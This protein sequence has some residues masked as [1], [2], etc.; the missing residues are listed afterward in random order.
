MRLS[1]TFHRAVSSVVI[2]AMLATPASAMAAVYGYVV[3]SGDDTVSVIDLDAG[4]AI[5][6]FSVGDVPLGVA[7]NGTGAYVVNT[8]DDTVSVVDVTNGEV[9]ATISVPADPR[10]VVISGTGVYVS[11][12]ATDVVSVIDTTSNA[13][14]LSISVPN[15]PF[16]MAVS[17][18]GVFVSQS[19]ASAVSI[20]DTTTGTV[21]STLTVGAAPNGMAASGTGMY[22]A[23]G[24]DNTVSVID[25]TTNTVEDLISV[26][27]LPEGVATSGTGVYVVNLNGPTVS[28]ID[29]STDTVDATITV[30]T[31]PIVAAAYDG[32]IYV[33]NAASDTVSVISVATNTV[34]DT[35]SVGD[36]PYGIAFGSDISTPSVS[37][38]SSATTVAETDGTFSVT[39]ALSAATFQD[40]SV[41]FTIS[42][43]A[44]G[45]G[46]DYTLN[47]PSPVIINNAETSTGIS[48]TVVADGDFEGTEQFTITL[49]TPTNASLGATTTH[50]VTITSADASSL[51]S[52]SEANAVNIGGGGVR[53]VTLEMKRKAAELRFGQMLGSSSSST[54][55]IGGD[56][57]PV[58]TDV[59]KG[60]WFYS[61]VMELHR[62]RI[63]SGYKD[64][65]GNDL[66]LYGPADSV[67]YGEF[68]KMLLLFTGR[69]PADVQN[70]VHW[71]DPYVLA[72]RQR[73]IRVYQNTQLNLD[74]FV[75]RGV[76]VR[77]L[78]EMYG[79]APDNAPRT[80]FADLP[81]D[82]PYA[83]D[84][85]K[86]V[87]LGL[88]SGDATGNTV[89]PDA[90]LN[91]AELA[92]LL[93]K[94][95]ETLLSAVRSS[96]SSSSV[97]SAS[98]SVSV[99]T[100]GKDI[101]HVWSS[102]LNVRADSRITADILWKA[103]Q[104]DAMEVLEI[105][106]EAW[107]HIR[108]LDGREG[109]VWVEY[110]EER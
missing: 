93:L 62:R 47:T 92:K 66:H 10:M 36:Q 4:S 108:T 50:T 37:F 26:G 77:A 78:L 14:E 109:Y 21:E 87:E 15:D 49:G 105:V 39:L 75:S 64:A 43:E 31:Q 6:T 71:A 2:V 91:R 52:S 58:F 16:D 89:R 68:A 44:Q 27:A 22:V 104:G 1:T 63:V 8:G 20:I 81:G 23:N 11:S 99:E 67:R 70:P 98:S 12:V 32:N 61:F 65:N 51:S 42:G 53:D 83:R 48:I 45:G 69:N 107:A 33:A 73:G 79:I 95:E 17:G 25:I 100:S 60:A 28:V 57:T 76:V 94:A 110:L 5:T 85:W 40:V 102:F 74:T 38:S 82:H 30:G 24:T 97:S 56:D 103:D 41:P 3:N 86:A 59:P 55:A 34:T 29:T 18:T 19:T 72:L 9:E 7:I 80:D 54:P 88:L 46:I 106:H 84:F 90:P 96:S 13:V 101:R 35:I